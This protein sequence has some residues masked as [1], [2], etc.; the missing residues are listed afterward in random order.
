MQKL[1]V[2]FAHRT[3]QKKEQT[4]QTAE[5]RLLQT[6]KFSQTSKFG[7]KILR[8]SVQLRVASQQG[9]VGPNAAD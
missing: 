8:F 1:G 9:G 3:E 6:T 2:I 7:K 4:S 5:L